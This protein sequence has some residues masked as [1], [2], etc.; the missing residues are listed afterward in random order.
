MV[1]EVCF[2]TNGEFLMREITFTSY[3]IFY[4]VVDPLSLFLAFCFLN[5]RRCLISW[6]H[7]ILDVVL[8]LVETAR[9]YSL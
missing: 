9:T 4:L 5:K 8:E 1:G 2:T 7:W 3:L 6:I